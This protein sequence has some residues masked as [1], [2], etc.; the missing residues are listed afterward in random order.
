MPTTGGNQKYFSAAPGFEKRLDNFRIPQPSAVPIS[1]TND[2][3]PKGAY[4]KIAGAPSGDYYNLR[5]GSYKMNP[6]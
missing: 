5:N 1:V 2:M 6:Q 3:F 4:A